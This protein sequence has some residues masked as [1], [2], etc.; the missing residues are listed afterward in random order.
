MQRLCR[1]RLH[2]RV[3]R[4]A[5][6]QTAAKELLLPEGARQLAPDFIGEIVAWRQRVAECRIVAGL[7]RFQRCRFRLG[8]GRLVD[9]AVQIHLVQHIIA[10]IHRALHVGHRAQLARFL[11]QR[12]DVGRLAG[13]QLAQRLVEIGLRRRRHAIR[14]GAKVDLVQIKL[15][16]AVLGIGLTDAI[17]ED[18]LLDLALARARAVEQKVL[19]DLLRDGRCAAQITPARADAGDNRRHD[20]PRVK[21]LVNIEIL[22][23]GRDEGILHQRRDFIDRRIK[24]PLGGEFVD[25]LA[26]TGKDPAD[27]RRLILRQQVITG[28]VTRIHPEQRANGQRAKD[29]CHG[30]PAEKCPEEGQYCTAQRQIPT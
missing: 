5:H 12:R 8:I 21:P 13:R 19:R 6:S 4:G 11:R 20:A 3:H 29:Q 24:A 16:H 9:I 14:I 22:V 10:P 7:H 23:L 26:L 15:Q 27:G 1:Q 17:G 30:H 2:R 25:D 18:Q 28:Q